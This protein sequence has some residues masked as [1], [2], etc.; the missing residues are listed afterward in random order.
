MEGRN[1]GR[2]HMPSLDGQEAENE[3]KRRNNMTRE[4]MKMGANGWMR[5]RR[6]RIERIEVESTDDTVTGFRV[7]LNTRN[8]SS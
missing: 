2:V 1:E 4:G 6:K 3:N 5:E 7:I 8:K